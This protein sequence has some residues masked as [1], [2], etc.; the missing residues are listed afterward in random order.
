MSSPQ[1]DSSLSDLPW[2]MVASID[3][4]LSDPKDDPE[5]PWF[6]RAEV[7]DVLQPTVDQLLGGRDGE[8]DVFT[9]KPVEFWYKN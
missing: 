2:F 1:A 3:E 5:H 8:L 9:G 6:M 7:D 4:L